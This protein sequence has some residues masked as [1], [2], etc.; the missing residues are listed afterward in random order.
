MFSHQTIH[1]PAH[2]LCKVLDLFSSPANSLQ[3]VLILKVCS[4]KNTS[5]NIQSLFEG[6]PESQV[7]SRRANLDNSLLIVPW[8]CLIALLSICKHAGCGDKVLPDNMDISRNGDCFKIGEY[9]FIVL[10]AG[11]AVS[12]KMT[13]NSGHLENWSSSQMIGRGRSAMPKVNLLIIVYALLT[14]LH[15]EQL[16]VQSHIFPCCFL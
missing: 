4:A 15:F 5:M 13:C 6:E 7:K 11:A 2:R 3:P 14:G 10:I 1:H 16:K 12:V 9:C 8:T